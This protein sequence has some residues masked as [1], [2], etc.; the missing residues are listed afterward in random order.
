MQKNVLDLVLTAEEL[1][2]ID[3][4]LETLNNVLLPKLEVLTGSKRDLLIM[5]DKSIG[6]VDKAHE[7][8]HQETDLLGS[9]I[10]LEAFEHD[11]QAIDSLRSI[12]YKLSQLNSAV[13]D[14]FA[15]AGS[16]AYNASLMV[17]SLM[18]NAAKMGHPGAKDK[19]SELSAR[20]PGRPKKQ[21]DE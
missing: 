13:E 20:F 17:Y 21:T 11:V 12:K 18:K 2:Q 1:T 19:V 5:G 14:S 3:G 10:D 16:E 7:V 8:A 6:F 4:A 15:V 9:F